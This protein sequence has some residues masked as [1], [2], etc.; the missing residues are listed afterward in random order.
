MSRDVNYDREYAREHVNVLVAPSHSIE[1][2][3]D[4]VINYH[5]VSELPDH[6]NKIRIRAGRLLA[7]K[8][9]V[10]APKWSSQIDFGEFGPEAQEYIESLKEFE[11]CCRILAYG[12]QF[13]TDNFSEQVV[14]DK[15]DA[16]VE[17]VKKSVE[18]KNDPFAAVVTGEDDPWDIAIVELWRREVERSAVRNIVELTVK[19]ELWKK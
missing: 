10:I 6:P 12:Y 7:R 9:A 13:K 18:A 5:L 14:T 2:F 8:P 17:R 4:T 3:G 11:A 15:F 19:G 16:V 1:T